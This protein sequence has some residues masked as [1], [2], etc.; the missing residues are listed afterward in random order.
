MFKRLVKLRINFNHFYQ[1]KPLLLKFI[2][3]VE[4]K[5]M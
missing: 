5:F 2:T 3:A 4:L 1:G